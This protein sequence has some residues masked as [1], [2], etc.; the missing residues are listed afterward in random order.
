VFVT[1][2]L[3]LAGAE[4]AAFL[5]AHGVVGQSADVVGWGDNF[6]GQATPPAGLG[7]VTQI[8]AGWGNGGSYSLAVKADG[9][10]VGWGSQFT[11]AA[12]PPVELNGITS[13][14]AGAFHALALRSDGTVVSW[15]DPLR[16]VQPPPAGL[17]DVIAISSRLPYSLALKS[18]GTVVGWFS[19]LSGEASQPAGLGDVT[20]IATG[21]SFVG[22]GGTCTFGLAL[23][24]N[25]TVVGWATAPPDSSC[26]NVV[27][28]AMPPAGL[29]DVVAIAA[30]GRHALALK[31]DGTVV[32]WGDDLFGQASPPPGLSNV[33]AIAAGRSNSLALKSDGTVVGWGDDNFGQ[34]TPPAEIGGRV[35]A[36]DAGDIHSLALTVPSLVGNP[37]LQLNVDSNP[38]GTAEAFRYIATSDGTVTG[39]SAYLDSTSTARTV[40]V[41]LYSD[42]DGTPG[43]LLTSGTLTAPVNGAWNHVPVPAATVSAGTSYWLALLAPKHAGT[44]KFRDMPDGHGGSTQIS[45]Q[46][47]LNSTTV[48]PQSWKSGTDFANSPASIYATIS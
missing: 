30:G 9:T 16:L 31:S 48:L 3:V 8:A 38:A 19:E 29:A 37:Q 2:V 7:S 5:P 1:A 47:A 20:A 21:G 39:L 35:T 40:L 34:S 6:F 43:A 24:A 4:L 11:E 18:D 32:A 44:I 23:Q 13:I 14:A 41:G 46:R 27:S 15:G 26:Y 33:V 10:V 36:I 42:A 17:S 28:P 12:H 22:H 25:G 45:A